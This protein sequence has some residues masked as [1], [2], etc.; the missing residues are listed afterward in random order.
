MSL[1]RLGRTRTTI[2]QRPGKDFAKNV[3][4]VL[5]S[6]KEEEKSAIA[7]PQPQQPQQSSRTLLGQTQP[8]MYN[9][10]NQERFRGKEETAGFNIETM[11]S[12]RGFTLK[13]LES[14]TEAPLPLPRS[15]PL[16]SRPQPVK[17]VSKIP[18][19]VIP[20]TTTSIITMF[21][22]KDI[23]EG[24]RFVGSEEKRSR[25]CRRVNEV[26]I[27]RRRDGVTVPF[28][29]IDNICKLEREDWDR[30]VAVFVQGPAWQFKGWPWG[31]K[32]IEIFCRIKGFHLMWDEMNLDSNVAKWAVRVIQ[33]S[34]TKR[35]LDVANLKG[36]WEILDEHMSK[37]KPHLRF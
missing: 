1:E 20:A 12:Y 5:Q 3:F 21:N 19:I 15:I 27:Q 33:L 28:R 30:V 14:A 11:A 24:L 37:N 6:I 4:A 23:L 17:R 16:V 32:P 31:G 18:I 13:S 22:V 2:L 26:L 35:Y 9:R 10:Y 29:V 36:F 25:G 34:R 8:T 7:C